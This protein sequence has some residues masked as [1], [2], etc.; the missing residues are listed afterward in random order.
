M[1]LSALVNESD[2][3]RNSSYH[4]YFHAI[5][6]QYQEANETILFITNQTNTIQSTL[7]E[8]SNVVLK[9]NQTTNGA[10]NS[11][12][13]YFIITVCQYAY[14]YYTPLLTVTGTIGNI[15]SVLVFFRTKLKKLSSSYYL[16]AL[17][18]S[19]TG[20]LLINFILWLNIFN[21]NIYS[22]NICCQLFTFLSGF[23]SAL[24][25]WFVVAFTIERFIAVIYPL[26]RQ[27]MCTVNRAKSVLI[28]LLI[29][30]AFHSLPL[31]VLWA[32]DFA[33]NERLVCEIKNGYEV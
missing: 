12:V 23:C 19:D 21:I 6:Q 7:F 20:F 29:V 1:N 32:P 9:S 5:D 28:G 2:L 11:T 14:V 3:N 8:F 4:Q 10:N 18:I 17:C 16:S 24:S 27:T 25:V 15:I 13:V 31:I 33:T 22:Q 26:K 30:S